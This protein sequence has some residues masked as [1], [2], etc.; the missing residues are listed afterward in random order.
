MRERPCPE[1]SKADQPAGFVSRHE[2]PADL[3]PVQKK[4]EVIELA[5]T[6][7]SDTGFPDLDRYS[8][9]QM[10]TGHG[11]HGVGSDIPVL[12]VPTEEEIVAVKQHILLY[13]VEH[14]DRL[15]E[16]IDIDGGTN[17]TRVKPD[18]DAMWRYRILVG[19]VQEPTPASVNTFIGVLISRCRSGGQEIDPAKF[20]ALFDAFHKP[21]GG[22]NSK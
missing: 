6:D 21:K 19:E 1:E 22:R 17:D 15:I 2:L 14:S 4:N 12:F 7:D 8:P 11:H 10:A 13:S 3:Q 20:C 18:P 5:D 9:A 16:V